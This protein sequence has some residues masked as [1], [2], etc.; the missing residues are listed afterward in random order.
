[1]ITSTY[2][3][4]RARMIVERCLPG[5]VLMVA[6]PGRPAIST[7]VKQFFYQRGGLPQGVRPEPG[8]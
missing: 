6:A 8:C 4:S 5:T 2:H 1:M 7:W 3:I